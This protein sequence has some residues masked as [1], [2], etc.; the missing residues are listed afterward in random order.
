MNV[1]KIDIKKGIRLFVLPTGKFKTVTI[2]FC[3][4]R[5]LDNDYTYNALIPAVLRRGCEGFTTLKD[6]QRHLESLYGALFDVG[7]QKKGERQIL[8]FSM[9]VVMTSMWVD[10]DYWPNPCIL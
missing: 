4:H 9:E 2:S 1:E 7:V 10:R 8:R 6:I 5:D 3:F